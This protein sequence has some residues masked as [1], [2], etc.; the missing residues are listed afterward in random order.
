LLGKIVTSFFSALL[1]ISIVTLTF[2]VQ[3][4]KGWT[5]TIYIRA[6]GSVYPDTAPIS[7]IDNVTY[8]LTDNIVGNVPRGCNAIVVER[9]DIIVDGAGHLLVGKGAEYSRGILING[10]R[11]VT[12]K[13]VEIRTFWFGMVIA[14]S[15]YISI[16]GIN[17]TNC[18]YGIGPS[19]SSNCI[20]RNNAMFG[21]KYNFGLL[22]WG[23]DYLSHFV[24][25][26]DTS[27]TV[28]GKP[29]LYL[30]NAKNLTI[31]PDTYPN[32]GYLALVN[33]TNITIRNL[34][35][36]S[37]EDGILLAYTKNSLIRNTR[38][39]NCTY[40][41][42]LVSSYNNTLSGNRIA[43]NEYGIWAYSS[44]NMIYHNNFVNNEEQVYEAQG[45][46]NIW[47]NGYPSGGNYWSNYAGIDKKHGPYQNETGSDGIGD[48]TFSIPTNDRY[49]FMAQ[50]D[51]FDVGVWGGTEYF[52]EVVGN[53][54]VSNFHFNPE[55]G[56]FLK[57][58]VTGDDATRGFCR[59]TIPKSLLWADDGW[60]ITVGDQ[61][62]QNYTELEDENFTYLYFTYNHST[63][64][65][66][67]QGTNVIPEFP[68]T[69]ILS[70]FTLT[71]LIATILL[72]KKRKG[73]PQLP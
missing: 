67:I 54:T 73:K 57:F 55:E 10:R 5:E 14:S 19:L 40:G 23:A 46:S 20:L 47:D 11:N 39:T 59:A 48:V 61:T 18:T 64:T 69:I 41:I 71:T 52:V 26:V 29:I 42:T 22:G 36:K 21:N 4:V 66:T 8:T 38:I 45:Y 72:K 49:P 12:I 6:D 9:N 37:N 24:H 27:N 33:S 51:T 62:I 44:N 32:V 56:A 28:N 53:S 34:D 65:V 70:L 7:S 13:N 63:Q 43:N 1:F 25:D 3:P 30:V 17:V 16:S 50:F 60:T 68:S 2:D 58:N 35:L 15:R 31:S